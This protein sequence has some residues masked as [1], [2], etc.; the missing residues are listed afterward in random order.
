MIRL[1][2]YLRLM[3]LLRFIQVSRIMSTF[4][5]FLVSEMSHLMMKFL[6]ISTVVIFAAHWIACILFSVTQFDDPNEP[7]NWL[8][9]ANLQD[10]STAEIYVNA[11]YWVITTTCTVGYGDIHPVTTNERV[12]CII[13]MIF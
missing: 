12:V 7:R 3:R 10:S 13:C 8:S 6:K 4:E 5:F 1:T 9:L 2:R 11:L